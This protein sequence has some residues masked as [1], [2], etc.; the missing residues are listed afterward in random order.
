MLRMEEP[1]LRKEG[2][3]RHAHRDAGRDAV[4][5]VRGRVNVDRRCV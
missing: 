5:G 3:V 4:A 1:R 2:R